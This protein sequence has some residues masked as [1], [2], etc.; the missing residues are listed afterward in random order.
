MDEDYP[1]DSAQQSTTAAGAS[2]NNQNAGNSTLE[3]SAQR[4]ML[5]DPRRGIYQK[6]VGLQS[7]S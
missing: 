4:L 3:S 6:I 2:R 5:Q 7:V 1:R